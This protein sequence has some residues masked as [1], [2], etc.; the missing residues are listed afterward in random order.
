MAKLN[1]KADGL[2][3]QVVIIAIICII[4][5]AV[6]VAIFLS[7]TGIFG[8]QVSNCRAKGGECQP[9]A[10]CPEKEV[11]VGGLCTD[12]EYVCCIPLG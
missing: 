10:P 9:V 5:L 1:K 7:K 12:P 11:A 8:T 3:M 2:S 4:V 6:L